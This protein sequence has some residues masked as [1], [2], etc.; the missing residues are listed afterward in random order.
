MIDAAPAGVAWLGEDGYWDLWRCSVG[1]VLM[2]GLVA[3]KTEWLMVDDVTRAGN[4]ARHNKTAIIKSL[5]AAGN[6]LDRA[7]SPTIGLTH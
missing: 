4:E 7:N 5:L 6:T 2:Q 1:A 3:S